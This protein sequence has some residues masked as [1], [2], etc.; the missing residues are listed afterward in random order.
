MSSKVDAVKDKSGDQNKQ[1]ANKDE[2]GKAAE[3]D[4]KK[5][6]CHG[7]DRELADMLGKLKMYYM[8]STI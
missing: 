6:E 8:Q 4:E 7:L 3:D 5:F 1:N 2:Q